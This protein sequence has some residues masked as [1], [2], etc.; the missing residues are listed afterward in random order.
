MRN[1]VRRR[2]ALAPLAL[3]ILAAA[4]CSTHRNYDRGESIGTTLGV[5]FGDPKRNAESFA[6]DVSSI[7]RRAGRD[8]DEFGE[9][10][11]DFAYFFY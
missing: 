11:A 2:I 9:A 8:A 5:M 7:F 6:E 3:A 1:P 4:S 10:L